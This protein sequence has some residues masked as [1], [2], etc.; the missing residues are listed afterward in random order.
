MTPPK[1]KSKLETLA[2][3]PAKNVHDCAWV[4]AHNVVAEI[5]H[6]LST[7]P[8]LSPRSSSPSPLPAPPLP[9]GCRIRAREG[10][11]YQ[12]RAREGPTAVTFNAHLLR[13]APPA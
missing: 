3:T 4:F 7:C 12:R 2:H 13:R 10:H 11:R 8:S 5:R 9:L 1:K 6:R